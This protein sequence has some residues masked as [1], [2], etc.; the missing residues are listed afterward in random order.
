MGFNSGLKALMYV[1]RGNWYRLARKKFDQQIL[2]GS[3]SETTCKA[4]E[5]RKVNTGKGIRQRC[6]YRRLYSIG[7]ANTL[8]RK[9]LKDLDTSEF[10]DK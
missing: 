3:V 5:T 7:T 8:P 1:I 6:C 2:H 9:V 4:G 10:K